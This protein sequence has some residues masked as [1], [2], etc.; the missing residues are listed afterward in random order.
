[1][2]RY[3]EKDDVFKFKGNDY[4]TIDALDYKEGYYILVNKLRNEELPTEV[5]EI[6]KCFDKWD[7]NL[8]KMMTEM[9]QKFV[10]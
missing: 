6:F 2:E 5:F 1:M 8:Q 4:I 10:L 7:D 3:L 9:R